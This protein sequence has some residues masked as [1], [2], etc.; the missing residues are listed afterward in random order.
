MRSANDTEHIFIEEL[1]GERWVAVRA[2]LPTDFEGL[3]LH[4][5]ES[6]PRWEPGN[7]PLTEDDIDAAFAH[8]WAAGRRRAA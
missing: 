6:D 2:P 7:A 1:P 4:T 3:H 8:G 5:R